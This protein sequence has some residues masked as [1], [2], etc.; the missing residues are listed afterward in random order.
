MERGGLNSSRNVN[1]VFVYSI[2]VEPRTC[3]EKGGPYL[4]N[5]AA[6]T[7]QEGAGFNLCKLIGLISLRA[8][9]NILKYFSLNQPLSR[10]SLLSAMSV[11]KNPAYGRH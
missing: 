1:N 4:P 3:E 5:V 6:V 11:E 9:A 7:V 10:F 8:W 2:Y